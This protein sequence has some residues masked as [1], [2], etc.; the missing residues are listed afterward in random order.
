[1]QDA[2]QYFAALWHEPAADSVDMCLTVADELLQLGQAEEVCCHQALTFNCMLW[3]FSGLNLLSSP[4]H[5]FPSTNDRYYE[6]FVTTSGPA[7]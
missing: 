4:F 6:C 5:F 3:C 2:Q 7:W 1:M